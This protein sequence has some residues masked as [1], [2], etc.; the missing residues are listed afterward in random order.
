M[1]NL[2]LEF[3]RCLKYW[4]FVYILIVV[5]ASENVS[6]DAKTDCTTS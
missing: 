1:I 2:V 6:T 4:V 3:R 5:I